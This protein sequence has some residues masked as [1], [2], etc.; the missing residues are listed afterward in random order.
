MSETTQTIDLEEAER[1]V[2]TSTVAALSQ[3]D[4]VWVSGEEA[5]LYLQGQLS[6]DVEGM[7]D[8]ETRRSLLLQPQ[9]KIDSWLRIY[10]QSATSFALVTDADHGEAILERLQ[11]FKLR[12]KA[13]FVLANVETL[14]LRGPGSVQMAND[15]AASKQASDGSDSPIAI[16]AT[17]GSEGSDLLGQSTPDWAPEL[18]KANVPIAASD[19]VDVVRIRRGEPAMGPELGPKTI[20]AAAHVVNASVDFTKGCYVGQELV[21]RIDSRGS[22]TPTKLCLLSF[23]PGHKPGVGDELTDS[24][25]AT[26]GEITS[27]AFSARHGAVALGYVKRSVDLPGALTTGPNSVPVEVRSASLEV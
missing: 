14:A 27:V 10:R 26:V 4:I 5:A 1:L 15:L 18:A 25:N 2:E 6:Q 9:G 22:S 19:L 8:G 23:P 12:T 11:R 16:D 3:V 20:P 13:E 17:W 24:E 7:A 21:A